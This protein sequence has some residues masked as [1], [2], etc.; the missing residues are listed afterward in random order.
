MGYP[1]AAPPPPV[2]HLPALPLVMWSSW[3]GQRGVLP[4]AL[5]DPSP[6]RPNCA[7]AGRRDPG[8]GRGS[9]DAST[10]A[11]RSLPPQ[12]R[13]PGAHLAGVTAIPLAP[14][15]LQAW[16]GGPIWEPDNP[17]FLFSARGSPGTEGPGRGFVWGQEAGEGGTGLALLYSV[18]WS[19]FNVS[20]VWTDSC[21]GWA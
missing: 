18:H 5:H 11:G 19:L 10:A 6:P 8:C 13:A 14:R 7:A 21:G 4:L 3:G 9:G 16:T 2:L 17:F 12:P 20:W 1:P 15:W